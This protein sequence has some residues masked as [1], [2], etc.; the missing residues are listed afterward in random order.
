MDTI[1]KENGLTFKEIEK[2]I[3]NFC[4]EQARE[5][6]RQLLE[7][8]DKY[9]MENRDTKAYRHK[10]ARST[11]VKTVFGEVTYSRI[12]YE[13]TDDDGPTHYVFLLDEMLDLKSVG[14]I[15]EYYAELLVNGITTKSYRDCAK[16][17]SETTGQSISSMGVWNVIQSLG[18][19]ICE[20]EK[21]LV[22]RHKKKKLR[23]NKNAPVLFE[24]ADGVNIKLQG[25]DREASVDGKAE[26]KVSIAYNGWKNEGK[27]R[28]KLN[29][30]IS[31]A[32][33]AKSKDFHN[34]REAKIASEYN[35]DEAEIRIINGDG[36]QWI[37]KVIDKDT[38]FQLDPFHRNKAIKEKI[39]YR[40]VRDSIMEY[41]KEGNLDGMFDYLETYRNSLTDDDEILA[42]NEL[43]IYFRN[44]EE[45][46]LP[47]Q[48]TLKE[49]LPE[50][51]EG[52][53]YRNMGT[54][55]NHVW[56]IIAKRMKH[57][58]TTWSRN[59]ANN[60][61]KILAK[62]CEGKLHEVTD[63]LKRQ[64]FDEE[65]AEELLGEITMSAKVPKTEGNGYEYPVRGSMPAIET[66][67]RGDRAWL[68]AMVGI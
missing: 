65:K 66:A 16:E 61:A 62:K 27:N 29:G 58:H 20:E 67:A 36:A 6:A 49:I 4:C 54:M 46:I 28:Y 41:I 19:N 7:G 8:Y 15:S 53:E 17:V 59:G 44:N 33:F 18:E 3:Y 9:L 68:L 30:K 10:G 12:L 2:N 1:I 23:G 24:E 5:I 51:P 34:I 55:E 14:L 48:Q 43:I 26:M 35:L 22:D 39:P 56:S 21:Q 50:S 31:F 38:Y 47:Y 64:V 25:K 32:G 42:A 63:K 40:E 60:L 11:T 52:L 13:H 45:G 57:N 37:K